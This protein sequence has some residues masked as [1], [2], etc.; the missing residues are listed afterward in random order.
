MS[1]PGASCNYLVVRSCHGQAAPHGLLPEYPRVWSLCH[2][3]VT[4]P[5]WGCFSARGALTCPPSSSGE[6]HRDKEISGCFLAQERVGCVRVQ[7]CDLES[8]R[9]R[10]QCQTGGTG[11][12]RWAH[13]RDQGCA[14]GFVGWIRSWGKVK[15]LWGKVRIKTG[16]LKRD[17]FLMLNQG[18]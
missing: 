2:C 15:G 9:R 14:L 18:L 11:E 5:H 10:W 17:G 12:Q 6:E 3:G 1:F 7:L 13:R 8:C 16:E 4:S